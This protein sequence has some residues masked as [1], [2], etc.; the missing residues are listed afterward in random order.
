MDPHVTAARC[1]WLTGLRWGGRSQG[2]CRGCR[3]YLCYL[4]K[5]R[6]LNFQTCKSDLETR[7]L[8]GKCVGEASDE[9]VG[10]QV[11]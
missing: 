5:L 7:L 6:V 1:C 9:V 3:S 4:S 8:F 2:L 11:L 10:G